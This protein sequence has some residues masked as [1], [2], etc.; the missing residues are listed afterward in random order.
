MA[1]HDDVCLAGD[2]EGGC[3]PFLPRRRGLRAPQPSPPADGSPGAEV[4]LSPHPPI[5]SP[6]APRAG[7]GPGTPLWN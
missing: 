4:P 1:F 6:F 5:A 3:P 2:D 7:E